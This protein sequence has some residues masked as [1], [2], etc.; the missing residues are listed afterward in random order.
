MAVLGLHLSFFLDV[1]TY[2]PWNNRNYL[3]P[4]LSASLCPGLRFPALYHRIIKHGFI[5]FLPTG[6]NCRISFFR[7]K[8][9]YWLPQ[10]L[11]TMIPWGMWNSIKTGN[12]RGSTK[13]HG[14][15]LGLKKPETKRR[16]DAGQGSI[17]QHLITARESRSL[18]QYFYR[19]IKFEGT[20]WLDRAITF[21]K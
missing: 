12:H 21:I 6:R 17:Q 19:F 13:K 9:P 14:P 16:S 7:S 2:L 4:C 10:V 5:V 15:L 18:G 20:D 3:I 8:L 11:P 1:P